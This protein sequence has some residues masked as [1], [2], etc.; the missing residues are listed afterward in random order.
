MLGLVFNASNYSRHDPENIIHN[1]RNVRSFIRRADTHK[2]TH[3]NMHGGA[4]I[5]HKRRNG[6]YA[7]LPSPSPFRPHIA[8]HKYK[9]NGISIN[10][11]INLFEKGSDY[12]YGFANCE[13]VTMEEEHTFSQ[14]LLFE[15]HVKYMY[16]HYRQRARGGRRSAR[17]INVANKYV[18]III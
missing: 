5:G 14:L 15:R 10:N 9:I 17:E 12:E 11:K 6:K 13:R 18:Y 4:R 16:R 3:M 7:L 1:T 8:R 2:H